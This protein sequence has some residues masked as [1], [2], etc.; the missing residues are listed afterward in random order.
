M[1]GTISRV[2]SD[3]GF[4]FIQ[5]EDG[6]RVLHAPERCPG[7]LGLRATARRAKR[8]SSMPAAATRDCA[9]RTCGSPEQGESANWERTPNRSF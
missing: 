5:G 3:K 7:R 2:I 8:S 1:N 4:G 6:Q 9:R